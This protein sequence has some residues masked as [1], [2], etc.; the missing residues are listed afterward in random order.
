MSDDHIL[1]Q[2]PGDEQHARNVAEFNKI[3]AD[4]CSLLNKNQ[5]QSRREALAELLHSAQKKVASAIYYNY[6]RAYE[7]SGCHQDELISR[8][9]YKAL[10][11]LS[12][13]HSDETDDGVIFLVWEAF[14]AAYLQLM[15]DW[16]EEIADLEPSL[17]DGKEQDTQALMDWYRRNVL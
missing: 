12:E 6:D 1:E 11:E 10:N 4:T 14:A 17:Y 7:L 16:A 9:S 15:S 5:A 13:L 3:L 2:T 8:L